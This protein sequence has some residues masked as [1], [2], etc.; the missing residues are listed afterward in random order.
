MKEIPLKPLEQHCFELA[1]IFF[2]LRHK[3]KHALLQHETSE[4]LNIAAGLEDVKF[5]SRKL[6]DLAS[7]GYIEIDHQLYENARQKNK[8]LVFALLRFEMIWNGLLCITHKFET[9]EGSELSRLMDYMSKFYKMIRNLDGY[10]R[11]VSKL[12]KLI[13]AHGLKIDRNILSAHRSVQGICLVADIHP[14]FVNCAYAFP[15]SHQVQL[16]EGTDPQLVRVSSRIVL[17]T[18]QMFALSLFAGQEDR[19]DSWWHNYKKE[20]PI[21]THAMLRTIHLK[22][23][24][25]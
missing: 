23:S 15:L 10:N 20:R 12:K 8:E 19:I 16:D 25:H 22:S 21:T 11:T 7:G 4:W 14:V 24:N 6:Y 5:D 3:Y 17:M 18:M 13:R 2:E 9:Q 1:Y